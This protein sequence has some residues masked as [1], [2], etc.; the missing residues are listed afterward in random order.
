[1]SYQFVQKGDVVTLI[2]PTGG[3]TSGVGVLIGQLFSIATATVAQTLEF[4]GAVTGV[5]EIAK[6]S[7]LAISTGDV[8]YWDDTNKV[9]NK[10]SSAQ[11][12]VGWAVSD[13]ANPSST[14]YILLNPSM[15]TSVAA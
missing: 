12:E 14:V 7:A 13:A 5:H 8:L 1:M 15:R 3:V 2:A 9:V 4:E 6:T 10:T 11:K